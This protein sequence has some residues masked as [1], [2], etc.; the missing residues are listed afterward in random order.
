MPLFL[1]FMPSKTL[2]FP[3]ISVALHLLPFSQE[4][5]IVL[6]NCKVP[7]RCDLCVSMHR[8]VSVPSFITQLCLVLHQWVKQLIVIQHL[9]SSKA[10]EGALQE[11]FSKNQAALRDQSS[12]FT[13]CQNPLGEKSCEYPW[14]E[15][16][17]LPWTEKGRKL[18]KTLYN[19]PFT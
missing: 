7:L 5:Q 1:C 13:S 8:C 19:S 16:A 17:K 12:D 10:R 6:L 9:K 3:R 14:K 2:A 15:V 4:A 11:S 18:H